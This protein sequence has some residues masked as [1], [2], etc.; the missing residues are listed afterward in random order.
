MTDYQRAVFFIIL[1]GFFL[2]TLGI[3]VRFMQQADSFQ[4][5]FYRALGQAVF[6]SFILWLRN[7]GSMLESFY[8]VGKIGLLAGFMFAGASV[9]LV[10]ALTTTTIANAMFV[11]SLA[12][13]GTAVLAFFFLREKI[14]IKT[15]IAITVAVL[16][17]VIMI[18]GAV[19]GDGLLGIAYAFAMVLF[20]SS[21]TVC[22]R[23]IKQGDS[24]VASCWG[25]YIVILVLGLLLSSF[26]ISAHDLVICLALGV[27]QIG[28][29]GMFFVFGA[30]HVRAAQIALL[31]ML[32]P[33]LSPLW[34][35]FGVGET[36]ALST[37]AGG[38]LIFTAVAYQALSGNKEGN[39]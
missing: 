4:I 39:G 24:L 26:D 38:V 23:A 18:N 22:L 17:V 1:S 34:V 8:Q 5:T 29:G 31:A 27:F 6:V 11:M 35:W 28:L 33:V 32:E 10:L 19:S 14:Q 16:G 37:L 2:S 25:A 21:F 36:P 7:R 9:F 12:P 20:Y 30:K 13:F 15:I 3:G